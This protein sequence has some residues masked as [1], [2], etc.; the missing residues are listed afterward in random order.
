MASLDVRLTGR[1]HLLEAPVPLDFASPPRDLLPR[2]SRL[3]A[4]VA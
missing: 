3:Q 1:L 2:R 4:A